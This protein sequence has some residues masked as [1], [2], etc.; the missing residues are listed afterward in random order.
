[1]DIKSNYKKIEDIIKRW[2]VF[3]PLTILLTVGLFFIL[4]SIIMSASDP[5]EGEEET[6]KYSRYNILTLV[7]PIVT[8]VIAFVTKKTIPALFFGVF[9]G[10][11]ML[12]IDNYNIAGSFIRGFLS[13]GST[14][15]NVLGNARSAGIILQILIIGGIVQLIVKMG[16]AEALSSLISKRIKSPRAAQLMTEYIGILI[17]Y[18]DYAGALLISTIMKPVMEKF[19]IS[20][21]KFSFIVDS[22]CTPVTGLMFISTWIGLEVK[23]I[24][25]GFKSIGENVDGISIFKKTMPFRFYN[26]L[27]LIFVALTAITLREFGPMKKA[28][29]YARK[30]I[31]KRTTPEEIEKIKKKSRPKEGIKITL[32]NILVPIWLLIPGSIFITY[33]CGYQIIVNDPTHKYHDELLKSPI[34]FTSFSQSISVATTSK[35]VFQTFFFSC[36]VLIVMASIQKIMTVNESVDEV[37]DGVNDNI[38]TSI[39]LI[40]AWSLGDVI[41]RMGTS[42]YL[43]NDFKNTIPKSLFPFLIFVIG[44]FVSFSTG[45]SFG[46]MEIIIPIIIPLAHAIKPTEKFIIICLS[47]A[48]SGAVF[49]DHCSPLSDSTIISSMGTSCNHMNHVNT[50]IVY[51][52]FIGFLSAVVC[53][54]PAGLGIYWYFTIPISVII[55]FLVLRFY[56]EKIES[57]SEECEEEI[58]KEK[59]EEKEMIEEIR[60]KE[61]GQCE[62]VCSIESNDS[63]NEEEI[64][65]VQKP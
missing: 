65:N 25:D 44:S 26:I 21:E 48:L 49:G 57:E 45:T 64:T 46:T 17:Y 27:T 53:Y 55:M 31:V 16:G 41:K 10:E 62:V 60:K 18:D 61:E 13:F 30:G 2:Y 7:P 36:V 34:G 47:S 8:I 32:W 24:E 33:Y 1:M 9:I 38:S 12:N 52:L 54:L 40:L 29:N 43:I 35:S 22:T 28:E 56:G 39:I 4:T 20:K 50:Q 37:I 6:K 14:M 5:P 42:Q 15:V 23:L 51:A 19:K 11:F 63:S 58:N 59:E 3:Y